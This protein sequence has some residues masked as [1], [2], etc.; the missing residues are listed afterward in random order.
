ML[1]FSFQA[2]GELHLRQRFWEEVLEADS[3][4]RRIV[5]KGYRLSFDRSYLPDSYQERNN[6]SARLEM[7]F[8]R[9]EAVSYTHLT[10]P[11]IYSV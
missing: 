3:Y 1:L 2:V 5:S 11:T 6:L 9:T 4:V 7:D 10:L 8:V